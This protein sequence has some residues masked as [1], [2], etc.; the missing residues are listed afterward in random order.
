MLITNFDDDT[1]THFESTSDHEHDKS[2]LLLSNIVTI[3]CSTNGTTSTFRK[4]YAATF[5]SC[6]NLN[7][8]LAWFSMALAI[9]SGGTIGPVF[10]Y[11]EVVGKIKP[12]LAASWR[13]L[14][15]TLV[16]F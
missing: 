9:I 4:D 12:C 3:E 10:K 8:C 2:P 5:T 1:H 7:C 6:F 13:Y 15:T 11:M 14:F 16:L